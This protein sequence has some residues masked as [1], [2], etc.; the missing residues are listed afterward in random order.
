MAE[1]HRRVGPY[2]RVFRRG[3][4]GVSIDGR[5]QIGRLARDMEAQLIAHCGG[6]PS[7]TQRLLID[8]AVKIRL[9]LDEFDAKLASGGEWTALDGRTYGGLL[10]AFRLA[11]R[12]LGL[13][14]A[15]QRAPTLAEAMA[16]ARR[17]REAA[18]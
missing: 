5:S 4:I 8:R 6:S 7:V 2:S 15:E 18:A 14:G 12:E 16:A 11:M 1:S 10:N 9:R 13:K 17:E 3:V